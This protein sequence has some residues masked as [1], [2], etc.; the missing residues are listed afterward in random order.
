MMILSSA[1]S[2][3]LSPFCSLSQKP[4]LLL[5]IFLASLCQIL[6]LSLSLSRHTHTHTQTH[7]HILSLLHTHLFSWTNTSTYQGPAQSHLLNAQN[8]SIH[9]R[10]GLKF[11]P[12]NFTHF[13]FCLMCLSFLLSFSL[14][15]THTHTRTPSLSVSLS[16]SS[17]D[18]KC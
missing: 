9:L 2:S 5:I 4:F 13:N 11:W 7:T 6:S 15:H 10:T 18:K 17:S 12:I 16:L 1:F 3:L 8:I 14:T